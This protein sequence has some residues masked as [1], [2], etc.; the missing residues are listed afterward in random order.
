MRITYHI[1]G[2]LPDS[3]Y[4]SKHQHV[5]HPFDDIDTAKLMMMDI[6]KNTTYKNIRMMRVEVIGTDTTKNPSTEFM[7]VSDLIDMDLINPLMNI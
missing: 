7:N 6:I 5:S 1:E 4:Y 2:T 3:D